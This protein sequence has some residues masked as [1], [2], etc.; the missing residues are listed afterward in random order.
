[1][2]FGVWRGLVEV[3]RMGLVYTLGPLMGRLVGGALLGTA[4]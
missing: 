1:M 3:P 2:R 4:I